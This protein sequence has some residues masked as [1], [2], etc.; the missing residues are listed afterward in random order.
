MTDVDEVASKDYRFPARTPM[1]WNDSTNAGFSTAKKTWLPVAENYEQNNVKAQESEENSHLKVFQQL[2]SMREH[3]TL[4][5]GTVKFA[6]TRYEKLLIY[7]R[8]MENQPKADIV[9]IA[10]NLSDQT[11]DSFDLNQVLNGLPN[12]MNVTIGTHSRR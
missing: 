4:K 7:K 12:I 6:S 5:Y 11:I 8:E 3:P 9:V 10:L 2:I 1:Q